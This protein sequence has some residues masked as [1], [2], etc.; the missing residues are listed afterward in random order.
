M[1]AGIS[2]LLVFKRL[3]SLFNRYYNGRYYVTTYIIG[4]YSATYCSKMRVEIPVEEMLWLETQL[5]PKT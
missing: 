5:L 2:L 1:A 4:Y 3:L